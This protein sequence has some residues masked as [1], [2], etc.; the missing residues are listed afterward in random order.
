MQNPG[1]GPGLQDPRLVRCRSSPVSCGWA[2]PPHRNRVAPSVLRPTWRQTG[3]QSKHDQK[4]ILA[5]SAQRRGLSPFRSASSPSGPLHDAMVKNDTGRCPSSGPGLGCW[6]GAP[7]P[8]NEAWV[9]L[10]QHPGTWSEC[11]AE[12][13]PELPLQLSNCGPGYVSSGNA[14][15]Q[16]Q[17][18]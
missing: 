4:T 16:G 6:R 8:G 12:P 11:W 13:G 5:L 3:Q 14:G 10:D 17:Y 18:H 1:W 7:H 15:A 9:G 2:Q